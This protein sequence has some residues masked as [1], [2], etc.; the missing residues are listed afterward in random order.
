M[1]ERSGLHTMVKVCMKTS[2]EL[3]VTD[4]LKSWVSIFL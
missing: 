4:D 1:E 3:G 2:E